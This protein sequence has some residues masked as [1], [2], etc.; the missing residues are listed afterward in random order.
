MSHHPSNVKKTKRVNRQRSLRYNIF[1][2]CISFTVLIGTSYLFCMLMQKQDLPLKNIYKRL[3]A[4]KAE[5]SQLVKVIPG[6]K[7]PTALNAEKTGYKKTAESAQKE[8]S[9]NECY[10]NIYE[11]LLHQNQ[12]ETQVQE[13]QYYIQ[14]GA[15]KSLERAQ[16]L[17]D[18]LKKTKDLDCKLARRGGMTIVLCG[19]FPK[20]SAAE[21]Y[22]QEISHLLGWKCIVMKKG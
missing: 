18:D 10:K 8:A 11:T 22:N 21:R 20:K 2:F 17:R 13:S 7:N 3:Q 6:K 9:M 16:K 12:P 19:S 4:K 15:F 1:F 14:V 5:I